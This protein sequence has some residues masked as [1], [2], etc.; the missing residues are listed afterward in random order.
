MNALRG[1]GQDDCLKVAE[2]S[3]IADTLKRRQ[4]DLTERLAAVNEAL[5]ALEA[6]PKV[7]EVLELVGR[8]H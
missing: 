8:V 7:A 2:S 1:I 3:S 4:K 5:A 6:N